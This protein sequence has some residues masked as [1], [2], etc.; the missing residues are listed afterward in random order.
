MKSVHRTAALAVAACLFAALRLRRWPGCRRATWPGS[1]R[2]ATPTSTALRTGAQRRRSLCCCTGVRA[3]ARRATSS[4]PRSS[5][6]RNSRSRRGP[7]SPS[8]STATARRAEAGPALQG[9]RLPTLVIL[10]PGGPGDH[11]AC[12][13][14]VD[15][16]QVIGL[17]QLIERR[18]AAEGRAGRRARRQ[19]AG[20]RRMAHARLLLLGR[21][22]NRLVPAPSSAVLAQPGAGQPGGRHRDHDPPVAEGAGRQRRQQGVKPDAALRERVQRVVTDPLARVRTSTSRRQLRRRPGVRVLAADDAPE[23]SP[24][25]AQFDAA[26]AAAGRRRHASRATAPARSARAVELARLGPPKD[27]RPGHAARALLKDVRTRAWRDDREIADPERQAARSPATPGSW[28]WPASGPRA[29]RCS[30]QPGEGA[31]RPQYLMSQLGSNAKQGRPDEALRWHQQA[32]ERRSVGPATRL[33]WGTRYLGELVELAPQDGARIEK[34]AARLIAQAG[35]DSG[36]FEGR[37]ARAAAHGPQARQ[38]ERR[39]PPRRRVEAP[40]DGRLV[41]QGRRAATCQGGLLAPAKTGKA[42]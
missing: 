32:W 17:M 40:A 12:V 29:T 11:C 18:P 28:D 20:R 38:L 39:R 15:A 24:L 27:D 35:R 8:P 6:A 25:V 4:R 23:R 34:T 37:S 30:S 33:Q 13:G 5:T 26:V 36:A 7:S 22:T 41:P 10:E 19:G 21:P 16:A 9:G 31:P 3:G 2:P 42:G 1:R 14:E